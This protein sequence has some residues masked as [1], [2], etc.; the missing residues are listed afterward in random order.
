[1]KSLHPGAI[2]RVDADAPPD[3]IVRTRRAGDQSRARSTV[4]ASFD[5]HDMMHATFS[6][7]VIDGA[8]SRNDER[9]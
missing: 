6:Q 9:R 5:T 8:D 4:T 1:M 2:R 7:K 3:A